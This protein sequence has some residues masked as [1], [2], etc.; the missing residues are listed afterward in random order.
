ME[1]C[2]WKQ[3]SF[4]NWLE[5]AIHFLMRNLN[6]LGS[7]MRSA[8]NT[9]PQTVHLTTLPKI[10]MY[11]H[12]VSL[13]KS[14]IWATN[15]TINIIHLALFQPTWRSIS[16]FLLFVT[17]SDS[18]VFLLSLNDTLRRTDGTSSNPPPDK[19]SEVFVESD[20]FSPSEGGLRAS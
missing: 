18:A 12:V 2:L 8:L 1:N 16:L 6:V 13:G 9:W 7:I 5:T 3:S 4:G 11:L 10:E 17:V 19:A 15:T 14:E 20:R